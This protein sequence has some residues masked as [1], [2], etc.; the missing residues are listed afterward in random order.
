MIVVRAAKRGEN[1][2][3]GEAARRVFTRVSVK[4]VAELARDAYA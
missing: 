1:E 2:A 3:S 4:P